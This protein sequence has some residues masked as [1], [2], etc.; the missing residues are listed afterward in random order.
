MDPPTTENFVFITYKL[1]AQNRG[2]PREV[3]V[4]K[5]IHLCSS[6][7][8][9]LKEMFPKIL[10]EHVPLFLEIKADVP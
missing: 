10:R 3:F 9:N 6:D 4:P 8:C 5:N 7:P 2:P 1:D